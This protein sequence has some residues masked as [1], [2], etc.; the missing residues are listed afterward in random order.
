MQLGYDKLH[1]SMKK[2]FGRGPA[3]LLLKLV[4]LGIASTCLTGFAFFVREVVHPS[5][6]ALINLVVTVAAN[7]DT[8]VIPWT[9]IASVVVS[10]PLALLLLL[11]IARLISDF[12]VGRY[13]DNKI[14][15]YEQIHAD[16]RVMEARTDDTRLQVE[17]LI[18]E[19]ESMYP[20]SEEQY[21]P[22]KEPT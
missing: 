22:Y 8:E 5:V 6:S 3:R 7:V 20:I 15:Q 14:R 11:I 1:E 9:G 13:L 19:A 2:E 16:L 10:I 4:W 21:D 17:S 12:G 18:S